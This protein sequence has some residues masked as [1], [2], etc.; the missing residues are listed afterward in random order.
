MKKTNYHLVIAITLTLLFITSTANSQSYSTLPPS[1]VGQP[2][3]AIHAGQ[4]NS[5]QTYQY[6]NPITMSPLPSLPSTSFIYDAG[7]GNSALQ[8]NSQGF[9]NSNLTVIYPLSK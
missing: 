9:G 2:A 3:V 7:T 8:F 1:I 6:S 5:P 4:G